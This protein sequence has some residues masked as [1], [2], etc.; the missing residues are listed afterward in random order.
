MKQDWPGT[1]VAAPPAEDEAWPGTPEPT[2]APRQAPALA[3]ARAAAP[4]P[5]PARQPAAA[6]PQPANAMAGGLRGG[7]EASVSP[8][9]RSPGQFFMDAAQ[10]AMSRA[11][12]Q[13]LLRYLTRNLTGTEQVVYDGQFYPTGLGSELRRNEL[14][15]RNRYALME[16]ADP[17]NAPDL[18]RFE[19]GLRGAAGIAG[20]FGGSAISDPINYAGAPGIGSTI[21]AT[22]RNV[23]INAG[24]GAGTDAL[25]Q[26]LDV[27]SGVQD[28]F[29]VQQMLASG[30]LN[31]LLPTAIEGAMAGVNRML[32]Q[33]AAPAPPPARGGPAVP[34]NPAAQRPSQQAAPP[35]VRIDPETGRSYTVQNVVDITPAEADALVAAGTYRRDPATGGVY[36]YVGATDQAPAANLPDVEVTAAAPGAVERMPMQGDAPAAASTAQPPI[37]RHRETAA[38]VEAAAP[39]VAEGMTRLWRGNRPNETGAGLNFTNDLPGIALPFR[40]AYGGELSYVDVPSSQLA[41]FEIKAGAAPGAEFHLPADLAAT[42]R[43]AALEAPAAPRALAEDVGAPGRAPD[44]VLLGP[45]VRALDD[46]FGIPALPGRAEALGASP[47]VARA[48]ETIAQTGVVPPLRPGD[49]T[50]RVDLDMEGNIRMSN[51]ESEADIDAVL[52]TARALGG[53]EKQGGVQTLAETQDLADLMGLTVDQLLATPNGKAMNAREITAARDLMTKSAEKVD[54]RFDDYDADPTP[55]TRAAYLDALYLQVAIQEKVSG[56]ITETTRATSA[57]RI[58]ARSINVTPEMLDGRLGNLSDKKLRE[59]GR[60]I[61]DASREGG[62]VAGARAARKELGPTIIDAI[63]ELRYFGMLSGWATHFFNTVSTGGHILLMLGTDAAASVIGGAKAAARGALGLP[64]RERILGMEVPARATGMLTALVDVPGIWR[65]AKAGTLK[66]SDVSPAANAAATALVTGRSSDGASKVETGNRGAIPGPIGAIVRA[67][68]HLLTA[69]DEFFKVVAKRMD[70]AGLALRKAQT[71]GS[72]DPAQKR[73]T[74]QER[75]K[76]QARRA[77]ELAANPSESMLAEAEEFGR[78]ATFTGDTGQFTE[79][80]ASLMRRFPATR[81]IVPFVNT[82]ANLFNRS[83]DYMPIGLLS[84]RVWGELSAGGVRTDR[85]LA[86]LTV[87]TGMMIGSFTA[88]QQGIITGAAPSDAAERKR[89]EAAGWQEY[90]IRTPDGRYHSYARLDPFKMILGSAATLAQPVGKNFDD[91]KFGTIVMEHL[92]NFLELAQDTQFLDSYV[93][94]AESIKDGRSLSKWVDRYLASFVPAGLTQMPFGLADDVRRAP[95]GALET[96]Q[97]R[98]PFGLS[99]RLPAQIDL[100]GREV[101][102]STFSS[103]APSEGRIARVEQAVAAAKIGEPR[104]TIQDRKLTGEEYETYSRLAGQ[105]LREGLENWVDTPD[106]LE[107]DDEGRQE[108][109]KDL[110]D[111][112]RED[113]RQELDLDRPAE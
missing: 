111:E 41:D 82:I 22:A 44:Q 50:A 110:A 97:A 51:I 47:A 107:L 27:G 98:I 57:L 91:K 85:A 39:P 95:E 54:Q 52:S 21:G 87:G 10:D 29:N 101:Q 65:A 77:A 1:L 40:E 103:R 86:K 43:V 100:L 112:A 31:A 92:S 109:V 89:L 14:E 20:A 24:V 61:R 78:V 28:Q 16:A 108:L 106:W 33:P 19:Q 17:W 76:A 49:P 56:I 83:V 37:V 23:G 48:R 67:P 68:S 6:A 64:Q 80:V 9:R 84:P 79:A 15:R 113:A 5:A 62:P 30:A 4:A 74:P 26:G 25:V 72:A 12:P 46:E 13:A 90:S 105:Y 11:S 69:A 71:E 70:I 42:A 96:M 34:R 88:A 66:L 94:L 73:M 3:P 104:R 53:I 75:Q 8:L 63:L 59:A 38:I 58:K 18:N 81:L 7:S 36:R 35:V 55:E 32:P 60:R 99:Q 45:E 93:D 102:K 2:P